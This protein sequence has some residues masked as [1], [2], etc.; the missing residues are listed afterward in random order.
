MSLIFNEFNFQREVVE[1]KDDIVLVDVYAPWCTPC[2]ALAKVI[3]K[4]GYISGVKVGKIDLDENV[5]T[6]LP[7]EVTSLPTML[8]FKNGEVV[9]RLV[10]VASETELR[11]KLEELKAS[12]G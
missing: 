1:H 2:R 5:E 12:G 6:C 7:Y 9:D 10:G 11:E 8:F 4:L 3:D